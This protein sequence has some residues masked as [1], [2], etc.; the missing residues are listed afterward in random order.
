M[1]FK[2]Y[3]YSIYIYMKNN[4]DPMIFLGAQEDVMEN[5][6]ALKLRLDQ[7]IDQGMHDL[8]DVYYNELLALIDEAALVSEWPE[9]AE[10]ISKGKTL[11]TDVDA[12]ISLHGG[13]TMSL[14]WPPIPS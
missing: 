4:P 1:L 8:D 13:T 14:L 5:L 7:A 11:E 10:V 12:W 2:N 3:F 6:E 9:L